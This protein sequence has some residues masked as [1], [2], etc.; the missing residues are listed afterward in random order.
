MK[1]RAM[2]K[3]LAVSPGKKAFLDQEVQPYLQ[4]TED[5]I[6]PR[7]RFFDAC[8]GC[9]LQHL[10]YPDQLA[11]KRR[12]VTE[13]FTQHGLPVPELEQRVYG[14]EDPWHYRNKADF[15]ARTYG[16]QTQIGFTELGAKRIMDIDSCA[17]ASKPINDCLDGFKRTLPTFPELK[18]K[19]HS[20]I[21]RSSRVDEKVVA[22][23]HTKLKD[24]E[25]FNRL[26]AAV[27]DGHPMLAGGGFVQRG[28]EFGEGEMR[29]RE[30]I[31]G[32]EYIYSAVSFFQANP[33]QTEVLT[34]LVEEY[35]DPLP[36]DI[37]LDVYSGV[38]LFTLLLAPSVREIYAIEDTP[39]S[40][41]D[42]IENARRTGITN[43][44]FLKGQAEEK[45]TQLYRTR[46]AATLAV[47]DPPRSGCSPQALELIQQLDIPRLVHVSCNP[48]ALARDVAIL[49][50][51][52]YQLESLSL[53][54]MFP[55]TVHVECVAYLTRGAR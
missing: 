41:A 47:L 42:A 1:E 8:G 37:V 49:V 12:L 3:S 18:R 45:L 28:R 29:L 4:G 19:L 6:T 25:T 7:C 17:I 15:N 32:T 34:R 35:A 10:S 5:Y 50:R 21:L 52:G 40:V 54:D 43:C 33:I 9:H 55:Q 38:G 53:V 36:S 27:R 44:H 2:S 39:S 11:V 13:A 20:V 48:R 14:M 22:L 31:R 16:G 51:G 26:T 24:A 30:D 46:V 23:Y